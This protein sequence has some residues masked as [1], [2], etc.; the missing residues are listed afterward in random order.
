[1]SI[2]AFVDELIETLVG[3]ILFTPIIHYMVKS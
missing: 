1:M 3:R 2:E